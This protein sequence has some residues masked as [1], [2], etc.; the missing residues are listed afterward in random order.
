M[1]DGTRYTPPRLLGYKRSPRG[2]LLEGLT[3]GPV[4][5]LAGAV[6]AGGFAYLGGAT[7]RRLVRQRIAEG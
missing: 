2:E 3:H 6:V 7:I 1:V 5:A 4:Y